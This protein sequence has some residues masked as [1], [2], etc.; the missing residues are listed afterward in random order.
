MATAPTLSFSLNWGAKLLVATQHLTQADVGAYLWFP[1]VLYDVGSIGFGLLAG[2]RLRRLGP[3]ATP[4]VA[5]VAAALVCAPRVRARTWRFSSSRSAPPPP[6]PQ[7]SPPPFA[8]SSPA[9]RP[10]RRAA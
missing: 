5:L 1:P 8:A 9:S 3:G 10:A 4:P 6:A 7:S 2:A